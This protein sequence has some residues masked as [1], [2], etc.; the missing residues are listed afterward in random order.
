MAFRLKS[1]GDV[2]PLAD[3]SRLAKQSAKLAHT[4]DHKNTFLTGQ[5]Y[6]SPE[7]VQVWGCG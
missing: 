1:R 7:R 4:L 5:L 6:M 2:C 3:G